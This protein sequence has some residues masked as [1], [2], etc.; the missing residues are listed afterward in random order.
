MSV[1]NQ[2]GNYVIIAGTTTNINGLNT[3]TYDTYGK[4]IFSVKQP[5]QS[6]TYAAGI[7]NNN[8]CAVDL[9][10]DGNVNFF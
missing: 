8:F 1:L 3:Y 9:D 4:L 10:Q 7:Y 5:S 2:G 6:N